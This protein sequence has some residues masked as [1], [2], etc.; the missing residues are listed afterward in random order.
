ML[1]VSIPDCRFFRLGFFLSLI[2]LTNFPIFLKGLF[3][4]VK[5]KLFVGHGFIGGG[6]KFFHIKILKSKIVLFKDGTLLAVPF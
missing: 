5:G 4:L 6:N 2:C 1:Y 3:I